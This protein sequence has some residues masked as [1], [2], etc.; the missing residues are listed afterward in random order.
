MSTMLS[1][2]LRNR[3]DRLAGNA[4]RNQPLSVLECRV[5]AQELLAFADIAEQMEQGNVREIAQKVAEMIDH[6]A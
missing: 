3:A 4:I 1:T 6:A 2:Q 5:F